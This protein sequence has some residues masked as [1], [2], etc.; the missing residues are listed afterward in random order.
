MN[1]TAQSLIDGWAEIRIYTGPVTDGNFKPYTG[2]RDESAIMR[3][4]K[5][6]KAAGATKEASALIYGGE[7]LVKGKVAC[8]GLDIFNCKYEWW[9]EGAK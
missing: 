4:V 9:Q 5:D 8:I 3:A 7:T 2:P 6:A 1:K